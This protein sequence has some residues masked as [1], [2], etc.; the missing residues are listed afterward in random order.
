MLDC[1]RFYPIYDGCSIFKNCISTITRD[2]GVTAINSSKYGIF[3]ISAKLKSLF[4]Y[5]RK[6][7][8]FPYMNNLWIGYHFRCKNAV[9]VAFLWWHQA[10]GCIKNWPWKI[11]EF[12]L[13]ILPCGTEVTL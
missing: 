3:C 6:I 8:L 5:R 10:V 7:F 4:N 11:G 1:S 2:N 12:L 13:L 9:A